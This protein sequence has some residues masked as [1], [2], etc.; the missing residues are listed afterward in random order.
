MQQYLF[1]LVERAVLAL[2]NIIT[3]LAIF[4]LSLYFARV[5]S[6]VLKRVLVK[7]KTVSGVTDLLSD[8]LRWTIIIF[9]VITALQRFFNVTAF[10]TGLGIIGFTVGFA[11]QNVMQNFVSGIIL[12]MQQPFKVG[13]EINVLNFDGVV[14]KIDL[15]TTE[16][17]TLDGRI[18]ILPNA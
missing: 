12:L 1:T 11:L 13:D 9:G 14:L 16:M 18:A 6:N 3:A 17:R 15:R 8:I 2:P 10:I 4:V 7:G 5:L